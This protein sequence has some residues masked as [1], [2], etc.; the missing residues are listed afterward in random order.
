MGVPSIA[1]SHNDHPGLDR[2]G[3]NLNSNHGRNGGM[4][5][6]DPL[7]I[8][9]AGLLVP[10]ILVPTIL[11]LKHARIDREL[12]HAERMKALELGRTLPRD[13]PWWSPVRLAA[14]IG[15]G[16]PVAVFL[17]AWLATAG[18]THREEG[19]WIAAMS[20]GLAGVIC[21]ALLAN[22][23]FVRAAELER[24]R[25]PGAK[26]VFEEDAFDVVG[27]RSWHPRSEE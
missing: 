25:Y 24:S 20:I 7:L 10:I 26:P 23:H 2:L 3:S 12:E 5:G 15:V 18:E 16:V 13:E 6:V 1:G 21:G 8:P 4:H 11:G 17:L 27:S 19:P 22:R 9:L 14:A